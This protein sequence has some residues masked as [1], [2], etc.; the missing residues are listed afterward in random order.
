MGVDNRFVKAELAQ[1][2]VAAQLHLADHGQA[3]HRR[4][5]GAQAV[6]Q[7]LGQHGHH[8]LGKV[9]RVAAARGLVV[10][11]GAGTDIV[12]DIRYRHPQAP[13]PQGA[14]LAI[15]RVVEI[16]GVLT[17]YGDEGQL[18]QI[19]PVL[20]VLLQ[21]LRLQRAR[22]VYHGIG[23]LPGDAV[24][25]YR[26]VDLHA[27]VQ[28][29]AKNLGNAPLG[30]QPVG[31]VVGDLGRDDLAGARLALLPGRNQDLVI[32]AAVLGNDKADPT[33]LLV[34]AHH[35]LVRP[36]QHFHD[37]A[38]LATAA[39]DAS[40]LH[41]HLVAIEHPVHLPGAEV[42]ILPASQGH[43]KAI[44]VAVSLHPAV[45]QV[46]L[47]HQ[48]VVAAAID[49][50][51]AVALHG[52]QPLAQRVQVSGVG[53]AQSPG[54][55]LVIQG[56]VG[57]MQQVQ[58]DL[59]AGDGVVVKRRLAGSMGVGNLAFLGHRLGGVRNRIY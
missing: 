2:S 59:A 57:L 6:G 44:T 36:G 18:A 55:T 20:L 45:Q 25:A 52:P 11:G 28:V 22:R 13:P 49:H 42:D 8:L 24:G 27:G 53:Q 4:L 50:E 38:F 19:H 30:A 15:H 56:A 17:V 34:A 29:L 43:G 54:D 32:D 21:R 16:P 10:Q 9:H 23:P 40:D 33:L 39:I 46:H 14:L 3:I 12:G 58:D 48:P 26:H 31:G 41:Q 37:L 51:L 7:R 35:A 47:V 5:E 1:L